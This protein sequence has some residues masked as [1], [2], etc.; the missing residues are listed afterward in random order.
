MRKTKIVCT[1]GPAT[2]N[3]ASLKKLIKAGMSVARINMSHGTHDEHRQRISD[4]KELREEL[5]IPVAILADSKGPEVRVKK[6]IGGKAELVKGDKFSLL[7]EDILGDNT[8]ASITYP[9]LYKCVKPGN[10]ILINDGFIEVLVDSVS[11]K[12]IVTTVIHGGEISN[13]KSINLPDADI[14]MDY[15]S[16]VDRRDFLFAI[17]QNVDFIALSFVRTADDVQAV[18]DILI[19]KNADDIQLIAK[20]ENQQ[21]VNNLSSILDIADGAMVAR[22]DMGVEIAF[23]KLPGIQ[24]DMIKTCYERGKIVITATQM[25]ESMISSPRPTRAETSDVANAI[26]D[27]TSA[28]MLSGET[29]VGKFAIETVKTMA[30][31]ALSAESNTEYERRFRERKQSVTSIT[32]AVSRATV[33]ASFDLKAKAIVVV[34]KSGYTAR[35]ISKFRPT[36]PIISVTVSEK[37]YQQLALSW[38][39]VP[40]LAEMKDSSDELFSQA[41]EKAKETGYIKAGDLIVISAGIPVG[42]TGTTN[43]LRIEYV[44]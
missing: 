9:N 4:I 44:K 40:I 34:S 14:D 8:R 17:E 36:C 32:D 43:T 35:Q 27:G 22:G 5:Q 11:P 6:F 42:V 21:G 1:L 25:L 18:K 39:V 16:D 2:D 12:E 3:K 7:S 19:E 24:K 20:I 15:I 13:N 38:G 30:K 26:H 33:T 10:F 28:T 29:A 37:S 41:V 31:I 23:D